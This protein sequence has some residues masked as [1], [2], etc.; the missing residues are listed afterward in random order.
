V[1]FAVLGLAVVAA[2]LVRLGD[3]RRRRFGRELRRIARRRA[4]LLAAVLL[5]LLGAAPA[6]RGGAD[7]GAY[8]GFTSSGFVSEKW[9]QRDAILA[10]ALLYTRALVT[11]SFVFPFVIG[12]AAALAALRGALGPGAR[13]PGL[14]ALASWIAVVAVVAVWTV[15]AAF[16]ER[17]AFYVCAPLAVFA[18]AGAE[19]LRRIWPELI[20]ASAVAVWAL[21]RG[22]PLP[23][24][25]SGHFF[26]APAESFWARVVEYRL[27]LVDRDLL[28]WLPFEDN[29][30]MPV[31][32]ALVLFV[33]AV[34]VHA[35]V[36]PRRLRLDAVVAS[37]LA[38]CLVAQ[39]LVLN[40]DFG[41]LL[42]GTTETP[43][44]LAGGPGHAERNDWI[45]DA[46][47]GD[48]RVVLV[49]PPFTSPVGTAEQTE[50]W[51]RSIDGVL[52]LDFVGAGVPASAGH[53]IV[54][55]GLAGG[56]AGW[57]GP[58]YEWIAGQRDDP[59]VQFAGTAVARFEPFELIRRDDGSG[60]AI[61]T[62]VG[63][64]ADLYVP[65]RRPVT[66]TLARERARDVRSV[67][68]HLRAADPIEGT[69][70]WRVRRAGRT[71]AAGRLGASGEI[72]ARLRVPTCPTQGACPPVAWTLSTRGA[73]A[74]IPLVIFGPPTARD[75]VSMQLLA[76]RLV[77]R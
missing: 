40:Y 22:A 19:H 55:T 63:L 17:Y 13:I 36:G 28:G 9:E 37:G 4:P 77:R 50:F 41:R 48:Q 68:L 16:E 71:R 3:G 46:V 72:S 30:W 75:P 43:G 54:A 6:L 42:H 39:V 27:L 58:S 61:W 49:P 14:V 12:V 45:D 25:N 8:G 56:L 7:F 69:V 47:P 31:A 74:D 2:E 67:V 21:A 34:A 53:E 10:T 1:L 33:A 51:N 23:G 5:L 76:A 62:A 57:R 15:G 32:V 29:S 35:L 73:A 26:A 60:P 44:G 11:G 59:R 18:V 20:V 64:E 52:A 70:S 66:M 65:A 38:L 24:A